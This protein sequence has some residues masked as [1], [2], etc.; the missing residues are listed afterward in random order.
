MGGLLVLLAVA[1]TSVTY[2]WQ[3]DGNKGVEY[4][5][6]VSPDKLAQVRDTGEITSTIPPELQGHVSRVVIRVGNGQV[7]RTVPVSVQQAIEATRLSK[8]DRQTVPIPQIDS[9]AMVMKPQSGFSFPDAAS[10]AASSAGDRAAASVNDAAARLKNGAS[11]TFN[12]LRDTARNTASNAAS[13]LRSAAND[14]LQRG[15]DALSR[16]GNEAMNRIGTGARD[17][18]WLPLDSQQRPSTDPTRTLGR[19]PRQN[20]DFV[21]PRLPTDRRLMDRLPTDRRQLS[22]Y[23]QAELDQLSRENTMAMNTRLAGTRSSAEDSSRHSNTRGFG[24][25]GRFGMMPSGMTS[26]DR[27]TVEE[28]RRRDE[29]ARLAKSN[30]DFTDGRLRLNNDPSQEDRLRQTRDDGRYSDARSSTF[31]DNDLRRTASDPRDNYDPRYPNDDRR[32]GSTDRDSRLPAWVTAGSSERSASGGANRDVDPRLSKADVDRLPAGAWSFDEYGNP[33][34]KQRRVLDHV[35]NPVSPQRAYE[36]TVGRSNPALAQSNMVSR[37]GMPLPGTL[38]NGSMLPTL[39]Q[40]I[41]NAATQPQLQYTGPVV[42]P[43]FATTR[44]SRPGVSNLTRAGTDVVPPPRSS[45]DRTTKTQSDKDKE[46]VAAQPLFNFLLLM[47]IVANVYLVFWLKNLRH[48]FHDLVS[49]KRVANGE[50]V[51]I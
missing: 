32:I 20:P 25:D 22:E 17:N 40:G 28:Q 10:R 45:S 30:I 46:S 9:A 23:T 41:P 39:G 38:A 13:D 15:T 6:Q 49:S 37:T 48:Q 24:P 1:A 27:L 36:L 11:S 34:D 43:R 8:A 18:K 51:G 5:V 2:G 4:I 29:A 3:P 35:G 44:G 21:G 16:A 47:S 31:R 19:D 33:I 12:D 14:R 50:P 42:D 26:A 7:P